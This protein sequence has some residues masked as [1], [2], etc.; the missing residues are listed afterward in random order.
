LTASK[1]EFE[2]IWIEIEGNNKQNMTCGLVYR[3]PNGDLDSFQNYLNSAI[4]KIHRQNKQCIVMGDFNLD[5]LKF[6]SHAGTDEFMNNLG[7][8][9]FQ[10]HILQPTRITNHSGTLIDNIFCNFLE[11]FTISGN[12]VYDVTDHLPNFLIINKFSCLTSNIKIYKRDYS[13]YNETDLI[14]QVEAINWQNLFL[15]HGADPSN[16]FDSFYSEISSIIDKNIPIKVLSRKERKVQSKPWVTPGIRKSIHIKNMYYKKYLRTKS[17][18]FYSRFKK[19][20]NKINHLVRMSKNNYYNNYFNNHLNDSKLVWK[21]IRQIIYMKAPTSSAIPTKII[22]NGQE[23]TETQKIAEAFSKYFAEIGD[24]L[25]SDIPNVSKSPLEYI[26]SQTSDSFYIY[27]TTSYEIE[28]EIMALKTS[29]AA[30]PC[31]LP[32]KVL[33]LLQNVIAKP[34][35][36]LFNTSFST[37]IVPENFKLARIL[38]VFKKGDH[39]NLNN[40]RPISL[41]SVFNKLLEK[42]MYNISAYCLSPKEKYT[43]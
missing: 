13:K 9:F 14:N 38:P 26:D 20:R 42:L 24:K 16:M 43:L 28:R 32:I 4:D 33:K 15:S 31:S 39:T 37:G 12:I 3:H 34:L 22:N 18:K 30:G 19:F 8:H 25:A 36:I 21:G 2:A 29:K 41:L 40:Y 17:Q 5:L 6:E 1:D 10:P 23:I 27:P 7:T 35:E 11:H